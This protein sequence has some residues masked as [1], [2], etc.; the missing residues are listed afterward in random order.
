V[1]DTLRVVR[2]PITERE[3][4]DAMGGMGGKTENHPGREAVRFLVQILAADLNHSFVLM[5]GLSLA[6]PLA[7]GAGVSG[8]SVE[9]H[10]VY[11]RR[12]VGFLSAAV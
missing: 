10:K 4:E 8:V 2:L 12:R 9:G 6:P 1:F 11:L 3:W 5:P 7:I